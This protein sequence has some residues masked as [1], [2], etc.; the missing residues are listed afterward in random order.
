[1]S[2]R[3]RLT[4]E[5]LYYINNHMKRSEAWLWFAVYFPPKYIRTCLLIPGYEINNR[6]YWKN[7]VFRIKNNLTTHKQIGND[8]KYRDYK[9]Q[10]AL[11]KKNRSALIIQRAFHLWKKQINSAK[12][13]QHATIQWIYRPG[14][15]IMKQAKDR[16]YKNAVI[17][18]N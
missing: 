18:H 11:Y 8:P 5:G 13:I 17:S 2:A 6:D 9:V 14:G 7:F 10:V 15:A 1:M 12:I 3:D 16:Y 4:K